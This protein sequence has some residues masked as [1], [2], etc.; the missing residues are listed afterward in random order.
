[1]SG[2]QLEFFFDVGSPASYLAWTQLGAIVRDTG[3]TVIYQPMLLGGVFQATGNAS[4]ATVPAKGDYTFVDLQR[5]ARRYGVPM[6]RNPNFPIN[7][8][9]YMRAITGMQ[10]HHAERLE[11]FTNTV[12]EAL[13]VHALNF[14]DPAVAGATL[15]EAGYPPELVQGLI[16]DPQVKARLKAVTDVAVERG[17]FGAPTIFVGGEIFWGQDRLDWVKEALQAD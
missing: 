9:P 3:A 14:N 15:A 4:P 17:V 12:F 1:M 13:W 5:Y 10:M 2:Q 11:H 7:T 6:A 8:L 16:A